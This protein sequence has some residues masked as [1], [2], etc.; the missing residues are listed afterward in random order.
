MAI[1]EG[2]R[3]RKFRLAGTP[4]AGAF[5]G[6]AETGDLLSDTTTGDLYVNTGTLSSPTW[7]QVGD[8]THEG[9]MVGDPPEV[10]DSEADNVA[11][12]A[13]DFNALLQALRDRGVLAA[14]G[15]GGD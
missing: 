6:E 8:H 3:R 13:T 10:A 12:L 9:L 7:T 5:A 4:Q 15:G 2:A 1:I 11:N 14:S